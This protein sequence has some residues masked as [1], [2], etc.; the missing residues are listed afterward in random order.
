[1]SS[2]TVDHWATVEQILCYFKGA[3]GRGILYSNHGLNRLECF[4]DSDWA[5]S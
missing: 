5:G 1:M 4:T 3:P 2:P